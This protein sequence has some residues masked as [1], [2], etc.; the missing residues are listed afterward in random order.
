MLT[1]ILGMIDPPYKG[2]ISTP[3]LVFKEN[4]KI[5]VHFSEKDMV[6]S[7]EQYDDYIAHKEIRPLPYASDQPITDCLFIGNEIKLRLINLP[8][9]INLYSKL[10]VPDYT[11]SY[12]DYYLY[13]QDPYQFLN[14]WFDNLWLAFDMEADQEKRDNMFE[15]MRGR[16]PFSWRTID[17]KLRLQ[18]QDKVLDWYVKWETDNGRP[19]SKEE[20]HRMI[21]EKAEELRRKV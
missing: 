5:V 11:D 2:S 17:A 12:G 14:Q 21:L 6:I 3:T 8:E 4:N 9:E 10:P 1:T 18:D 13:E 19:I 15:V 20:L 7:Q 16:D